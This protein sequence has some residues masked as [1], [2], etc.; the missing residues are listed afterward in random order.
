MS[1][2]CKRCEAEVTGGR[3]YCKTHNDQVII[4]LGG[5][6]D[7][8]HLRGAVFVEK[9]DLSKIKAVLKHQNEYTDEST[10]DQSIVA[11]AD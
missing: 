4:E 6:P 7:T 1:K 3:L 10:S 9:P 5:R 2:K 11:E 8:G